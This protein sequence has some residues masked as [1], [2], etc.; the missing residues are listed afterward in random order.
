M[1]MMRKEW[2]G[3]KRGKNWISADPLIETL[4]HN[5][6]YPY[7]FIIEK[8]IIIVGVQESALGSIREGG[9]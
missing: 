2:M 4:T 7:L 6:R 3:S 5:A 9:N 8:P 1:R